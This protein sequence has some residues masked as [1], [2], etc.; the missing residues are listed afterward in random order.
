[1]VDFF[2]RDKRHSPR[3][4]LTLDDGTQQVALT[5]GELLGIV[6]L[7]VAEARRQYHSSRGDRTGKAASPGFVASGFNAAFFEKRLQHSLCFTSY[8]SLFLGKITYI[9]RSM[10]NENSDLNACTSG[11][12]GSSS[13]MANASSRSLSICCSAYSMPPLLRAYAMSVSISSAVS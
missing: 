2:G 6:E 13:R 3:Q 11:H 10:T 7:L 9:L 5:L 1:M 12:C 4:S 8:L